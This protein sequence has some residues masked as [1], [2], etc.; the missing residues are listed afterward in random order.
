MRS[1]FPVASAVALT[2]SL[3]APKFGL[4]LRG[5]R[6]IGVAWHW[7]PILNVSD[8]GLCVT[9]T[10]QVIRVAFATEACCVMKEVW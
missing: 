6:Y 3:A 8:D 5:Y 9:G 1:F 7:M 10:E 4:A 2:A